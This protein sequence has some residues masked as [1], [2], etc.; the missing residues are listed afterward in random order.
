MKVTHNSWGV[1]LAAG[2][3]SRLANLTRDG[4]G[5]SVPKQFCSLNGGDPLIGEAM[6][7]ARAVASRSRICAVVAEEHRDYWRDSQLGLSDQNVIVQPCN[8]GTAV[9]VLL[10]TLDIE[11][12]DPNA[13]I[14]F[15]PADHHVADE[16]ALSQAVREAVRVVETSRKSLV[17]IGVEPDDAD[18][19]LGYLIP[20]IWHIDGG[21][22]VVQFVEK[23]AVAVAR[24]L[25]AKGA[26]WNTFIFAGRAATL[27]SLLRARLGAQ[28]D[29]MALLID[30][31]RLNGSYEALAQFYRSLPEVDFSRLL[32]RA[33]DISLRAVRAPACGWND[34]GT[35]RRL[36]DTLQRLRH[37][38]ARSRSFG[39]AHLNLALQHARDGMTT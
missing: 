27:S 16:S 2:S 12:R 15:F 37:L 9:G 32:A 31:A 17:L 4:R 33:G 1:V 19:E 22:D 21:R 10:A 28:V 7:R 6:A 20:G 23:P 29:Q 24:Q 18:P 13:V 8:R 11:K 14:S 38:R 34:L 30:R 35:P 36:A 3:G 39:R 25:I 26:L 5:V